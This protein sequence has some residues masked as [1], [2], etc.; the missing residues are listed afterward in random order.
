MVTYT[1]KFNS[2]KNHPKK[3]QSKK[4]KEIIMMIDCS[5]KSSRAKEE[6]R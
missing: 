5:L 4:I 1:N 6:K 2:I 3:N